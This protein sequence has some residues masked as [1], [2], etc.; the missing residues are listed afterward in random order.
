[1]LVGQSTNRLAILVL[2]D[3]AMLNARCCISTFADTSASGRKLTVASS[4]INPSK[5]PLTSGKRPFALLRSWL[6]GS[7]EQ[8]SAHSIGD[9]RYGI[10]PA[11]QDRLDDT[12]IRMLVAWL[13][14]EKA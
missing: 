5:C 11:F 9:G 1:L 2:I 14:R 6:Y 7:A 8:D 10:M 13:S 4:K 12:Q 3:A